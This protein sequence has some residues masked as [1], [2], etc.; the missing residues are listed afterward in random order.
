MT[1]LNSVGMAPGE[2]LD[3]PGEKTLFI[4]PGPPPEFA[5]VLEEH[6]IPWLRETF[7][8]AVPL[9]ERVLRIK[10]ISESDIVTRLELAGYA[11]LEV[12]LGF[13]PGGGRVE[14]RLSAPQK[15]A[16]ALDEAERILQ[17]LLHDHLA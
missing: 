6:I 2:R 3:L 10:E 1:L 12:S 17:E 14:I 5:A 7:H 16:E 13:Y 15:N 11:P 9:K 8:D 4:I